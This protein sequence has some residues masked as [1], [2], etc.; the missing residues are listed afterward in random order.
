[1]IRKNIDKHED[2]E[3]KRHN[4]LL[5]RTIM[6]QRQAITSLKDQLLPDSE[7]IVLR[8]KQD[9]LTGKESFVPRFPGNPSWLFSEEQ[10]IGDYKAIVFVEMDERKPEYKDSYGLY[11]RFSGPG[12]FPRNV[13]FTMEVVHHDDIAASAKKNSYSNNAFVADQGKGWGKVLSKAAIAS[14]QSPYVKD[15]YVTFKITFKFTVEKVCEAVV[16]NVQEID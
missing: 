6:E 7:R 8:V 4:R 3:C 16:G 13:D 5:L 12:A 9:M 14:P 2:E 11:L 10:V 15:G 1:M